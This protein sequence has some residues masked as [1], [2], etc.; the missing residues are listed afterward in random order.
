[1]STMSIVE[2]IANDSLILPLG[3]AIL[4]IHIILFLLFKYVLPDGPWRALPSFTAH[5]VIAFVLM[6][7]QTYVGF[8]NYKHHGMLIVN[9]GGLFM[10][11]LA[12]GVS[13]TLANWQNKE[14]GSTNQ[15][16]V[17]GV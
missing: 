3:L 17:A 2:S 5:Q 15:H 7:Y 4:S 13:I 6:I 16:W 8:V 11:R 14:T 10:A 12:I 9:E 1:M